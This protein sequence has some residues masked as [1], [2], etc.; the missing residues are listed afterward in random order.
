MNINWARSEAAAAVGERRANGFPSAFSCAGL[1]L[2]LSL[3][4]L[5]LY[6]II[7]TAALF[8]FTEIARTSWRS[9]LYSPPGVSVRE[10]ERE[11]ICVCLRV[12]KSVRERGSGEA[13]GMC[14][15]ST[16]VLSR[17]SPSCSHS[18]IFLG[19]SGSKGSSSSAPSH[20]SPALFFTAA[21]E[22]DLKGG[23]YFIFMAVC[24]YCARATRAFEPAKRLGPCIILSAR[25]PAPPPRRDDR[26]F[27]AAPGADNRWAASVA[28][29][30]SSASGS[31]ASA[32]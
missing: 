11:C 23:T 12:C 20:S 15:V 28:L 21:R 22:L 29:I 30:G 13:G 27:R 14:R 25:S 19:E 2:S 32:A 6:T 16:K 31:A 3:S 24:R 8:L 1:S 10:R 7:S 4:H 26:A 18:V 5:P 9:R 17:L